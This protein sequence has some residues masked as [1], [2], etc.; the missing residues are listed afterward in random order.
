MVVNPV[1]VESPMFDLDTFSRNLGPYK[2]YEWVDQLPASEVE[3]A[4]APQSESDKGGTG[5]SGT[6]STPVL[7]DFY[8]GNSL[9]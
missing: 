2:D 6:E 9:V 3:K 5:K 7:N 4:S 1:N 8:L